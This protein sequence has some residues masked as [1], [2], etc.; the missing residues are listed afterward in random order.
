ME[1]V[2]A[3]L[4][5]SLD[6][7]CPYCNRDIDLFLIDDNDYIMKSIFNNKWN[8]L[9]GEEIICQDCGTNMVISDI[10]W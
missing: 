3:L 7:S 6:I 4:N 2:E 5:A 1:N 8:D 9:R 10:I